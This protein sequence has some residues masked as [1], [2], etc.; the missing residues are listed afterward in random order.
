MIPTISP[1]I[2]RHILQHGVTQHLPKLT[3]RD[4]HL[5]QI[6]GKAIA[7][8]GVRR[9]GK[10]SL[11][12]HLAKA[13]VAN[14]SPREGHVFLSFE[15]ERLIGANV[16][17][18]AWLIEEHGRQYPSLVTSRTVYLDE[19]HLV[20]G[21]ET[22]VRRLM[23]H[24][25]PRIFV[26]GLSAKLL[27]R[28][29][30]TSLR[31]RGLEVLVHPFSFRESLRHRGEEVAGTWADL[32]ATQRNGLDA[33]LARYL[34]EGGFPEAQRA[35][36]R[37]RHRLLMSYVDVM[38]LR[39]VAERH[40]ISN[41]VALRWLQ[42]A[43][44]SAPGGLFTVNRFHDTLKSQGVPVAKETLQAYVGHLEDAFLIRTVSMHST[45]E[46]QR[47]V[48]PRKAYPIDTALIPL[49][50]RAGRTHRGRALETV[51]L[52]ELERR[53]YAVTWMRVDEDW[54]VDFL[55][56]RPGDPPLLMQV[57]TDAEADATWVREVR[58]LAIAAERMPH[59][60]AVL[61][62]LN[63]TPPTHTLPRPI[64]WQP[65]A[66]WLIAR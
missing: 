25:A 7:V 2:L 37:D 3:A 49:Y 30:A 26:S 20:A 63:N 24:N 40:Q 55:A 28:E 60:R 31:G 51:V 36:A 32:D 58:S 12:R 8:V 19:I 27:S 16:A 39:D 13:A 18:V 15:D 66:E 34:T 29:V 23:D 22:L 62:T 1:D 4:L 41:L 57:C 54:E 59:A 52:L 38:V 65:T 53:G 21:W 10:T 33:L 47:M 9:G 61:L 44:L 5:P 46:R 43:L 35:D 48:N 64:E 50:E 11:L 42:R 45:S 6:P 14:G 17:D 56:E